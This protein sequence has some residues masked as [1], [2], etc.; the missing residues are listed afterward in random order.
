MSERLKFAASR[1]EMREWNGSDERR[2]P[3]AVFLLHER[4]W[5]LMEKFGIETLSRSHKQL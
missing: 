4:K 2:N 3:V 1:E 5:L